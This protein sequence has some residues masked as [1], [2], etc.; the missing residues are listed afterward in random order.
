MHRFVPYAQEDRKRPCP[1]R[2]AN[3]VQRDA[4]PLPQGWSFSSAGQLPVPAALDARAPTLSCSAPKR[5]RCGND[6]ILWE[7]AQPARAKNRPDRQETSLFSKSGDRLFAFF[8]KTSPN[9]SLQAPAA[10]LHPGKAAKPPCRA[11]PRGLPRGE[12]AVHGVP[13][14]ATPQRRRCVPPAAPGRIPPGR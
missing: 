8:G 2:S 14:G 4:E 9:L 11:C 7:K 13:A 12:A 6:T 1:Q 5:G 3:M 10:A